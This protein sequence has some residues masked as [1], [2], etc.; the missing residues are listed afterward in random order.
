MTPTETFVQVVSILLTCS[1]LSEREKG[2]IRK[3]NRY[4]ELKQIAGTRVVLGAMV[5]AKGL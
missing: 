2:K 4:V 5:K 3:A 1:F